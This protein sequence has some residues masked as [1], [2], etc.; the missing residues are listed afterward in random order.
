MVRLQRSPA[1]LLLVAL[2]DAGGGIFESEQGGFR[3]SWQLNENAS[4]ATFELTM[5]AT[6]WAAVGFGGG[7]NQTDMVVCWIDAAGTAHAVD[8]FGTGHHAPQADTSLGGT[9]DV[10]VLG[11]SRN[12]GSMTVSFQRRLVTGDKFDFPMNASGAFNLVY[13]WHNGVAGQLT[14]HGKSHN[15]VQLDLS[16]ADGVPNQQFGNEQRGSAARGLVKM[17]TV[18]ALASLNS[19]DGSGAETTAGFP[20]SSVASYV[21]WG[22]GRPLLLLSK[23]ER[24]IINQ[25][26]DVRC[27]LSLRYPQELANDT[28]PMAL[29]RATL[30]GVLHQVPDGDVKEAQKKYLAHHPQAAWWMGFKDFSFYTLELSDVYWVGGF[31]GAHYIGWIKPASY[32]AATPT[33]ATALASYLTAASDQASFRRAELMI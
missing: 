6:G 9:D 5:N 7:M 26:H 17:M 28:D 13:A 33:S 31:G 1:L 2:A 21:D 29:P 23:L 14:Y 25:E 8:S 16:M 12:G 4:E 20:F 24:N 30:L 3:L 11:G 15:H 32:L 10:K 18:G 27:S 22:D 19:A